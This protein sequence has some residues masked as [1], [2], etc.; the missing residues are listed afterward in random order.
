MISGKACIFQEPAPLF[1]WDLKRK[2]V[3]T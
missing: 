3:P 1:S 2:A